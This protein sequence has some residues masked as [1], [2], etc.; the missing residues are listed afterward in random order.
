VGKHILTATIGFD[1]V[2]ER[3]RGRRY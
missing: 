3:K 1:V 2:L